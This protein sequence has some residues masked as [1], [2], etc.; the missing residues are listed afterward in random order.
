MRESL[1]PKLEDADEAEGGRDRLLA[2]ARTRASN[3][4]AGAIF[5]RSLSVSAG[6]SSAGPPATAGVGSTEAAGASDYGLVGLRALHRSVVP[7]AA[8][9]ATLLAR[10]LA[11]SVLPTNEASAGAAGAGAA[12]SPAGAPAVLLLTKSTDNTVDIWIIMNYR[13]RPRALG[14][15]GSRLAVFQNCF[16]A[17]W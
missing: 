6:V 15:Q 2:A 8:R 11:P 5:T 14:W 9:G 4:D 1:P 16:K 7:R 17:T 10:V 3:P 13:T 12:A